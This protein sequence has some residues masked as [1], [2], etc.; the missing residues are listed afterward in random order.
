[1][2]QHLRISYGPASPAIPTVP[3][4]GIRQ[5]VGAGGVNGLGD[6]LQARRNLARLGYAPRI[7]G[8]GEPDGGLAA[9]QN[10]LRAYQ[11]ARGIKVD[12]RDT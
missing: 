4:P 3:P 9:V 1:M 5:S 7:A 12:G 6:L 11:Q 2:K 8:I 10:G